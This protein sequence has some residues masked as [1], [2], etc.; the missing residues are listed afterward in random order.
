MVGTKAR[1]AVNRW[2][3][4]L[5]A[6]SHTYVAHK[7]YYLDFLVIGLQS[8]DISAT[9][10]TPIAAISSQNFSLIYLMQSYYNDLGCFRWINVQPFSIFTLWKIVHNPA[11]FDVGYYVSVREQ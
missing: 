2:F 3:I 9:A 7:F 4:S 5:S 8:L 6:A 1:P 11:M 10:R